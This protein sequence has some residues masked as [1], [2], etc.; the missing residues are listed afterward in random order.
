MGTLSRRRRTV[1]EHQMARGGSWGDS[2]Q[3]SG[4]DLFG[5]IISLYVCYR[6]L[7]VGAFE[8]GTHHET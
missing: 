2:I 8:R 5:A 4:G 6:T 3:M 1:N 7:T